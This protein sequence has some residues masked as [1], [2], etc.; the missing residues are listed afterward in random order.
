MAINDFNLRYS[1]TKNLTV[2]YSVRDGGVTFSLTAVSTYGMLKQAFSTTGGVHAVIGADTDG[3]SKAVGEVV[4]DFEVPQIS[5]G[6]PSTELSHGTTFPNSVRVYPSDALQAAALA[7]IVHAFGW[8]RV[9]VVQSMDT[10]GSDAFGQFEYSA[11]SYNINIVYKVVLELA[12]LQQYDPKAI[13]TELAAI[14]CEY[15]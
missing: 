13:A 8:S 7:E 15:R 6:S 2:K 9:F 5:Y 3:C 14:K 1:S 12:K 10:F 11:R 4:Q